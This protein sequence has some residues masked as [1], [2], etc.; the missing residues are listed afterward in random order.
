VPET[1]FSF[2]QIESPSPGSSLATGKHL[3]RGWVWTKTGGSFVDIRASIGER[4]FPGV[5]GIPR[6]DLAVHFNTRRPFALAEFHVAIEISPGSTRVTLEA[7][8]IEGRWRPFQTADYSIDTSASRVDFASP[9]GPLR[10]HE[11]GR[12]LQVLLREQRRNARRSPLELAREVVST[13]PYPRDLQHP[14]A[15][16]HGHLD[17]PAAVARSS[18][19]RSAVLGYLF[20]ETRPIQRVLAT[21]DLQTWQAIDHR[22]PSPNPAGYFPQFPVAQQCAL[23]GLIDVP[24]QLPN[25]VTLRLYAELT[26]GSVHLC[27]VQR[28][29]LFTSED[30]KAPYP[31]QSSASFDGSLVALRQALREREIAVVEDEAMT[32]ELK[33]LSDDFSLRAPLSPPSPVSLTTAPAF[34]DA[35]L[36]QNV[37]LVT[38]NLDLEGAPLFLVDYAQHLVSRGVK[39]GLLSPAEGPL[40]MRFERFG[41]TVAVINAGSIFT[42]ASA[43][44]AQKLIHELPFNFAVFDLVVCNTFTTFWAVHAAKATGR[45]VLLYVHESTT[46]ASFYHSRATPDVIALVDRAFELADCVSFTTASTRSYHTDYGRPSRHRLTPG[47]IDVAQLDAWR[48]QNRRETM[49]ACF[50]LKPGELLVTNVGTVSGRK[51]QHIFARAVDL[52]WQRHPALAARTHFVMLG[53]RHTSFDSM[54][55][56]LL[57]QLGRSNLIVHPETADYLPY[58]VAADL[59]VCSSYEES[60]PRVILETMA[61]GTPILSSNVQGVPE[62]VR[63]D[64]EATLIPPGD[65]VALCEAMARLL[66][67]PE[68]G[69]SLA[70]RARARVVSQF[71]AGI[72]LPR[73]AALAADVASGRIL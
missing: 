6:A 3:V 53:G 55:G 73:H 45:R 68:I 38:H 72:L 71:E 62:L 26:D 20:H 60:S 50:S 28:S 25:P 67:S 7:L 10:W 36:P 2:S 49:R 1:A 21:F 19:G 66:L 65:T 32:V 14:P 12:A 33:R 56:E 16:F 43:E 39:V 52:L 8:D 24:A 23:Y 63:P 59:F 37:L 51:G 46:P 11:F 42:A 27:F 15:P 69:N 48:A 31:S 64:L 30:E 35:A 58:Y 9:S 4:F 40:R 54:L 47:W 57:D 17:E 13:I 18:F 41:V 70:A 44:I 61:C 22:Q 34:S 5:H 29:R